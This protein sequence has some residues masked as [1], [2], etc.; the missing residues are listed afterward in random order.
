M[1]AAGF[2][3][4]DQANVVAV[5]LNVVHD[6]PEDAAQAELVPFISGELVREIDR[7]DARLER[8][9]A[10]CHPHGHL[11]LGPRTIENGGQRE[12]EVLERFDRQLEADRKA[13]EHE[14]RDAVE[15]A[16][17]RKRECDF[18]G[19]RHRHLCTCR[20]SSSRSASRRRAASLPRSTASPK[21]RL[22]RSAA[23]PCVTPLARPATF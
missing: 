11:A 20:S 2:D 7:A 21:L 19:R 3:L 1:V 23:N 8:S 6:R 22:A 14:M 10:Q 9:V 4:L 5:D 13:A 12:L 16:V 15:I 18:V 17:T